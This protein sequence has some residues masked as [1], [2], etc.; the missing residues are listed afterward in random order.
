MGFVN[1]GKDSDEALVNSILDRS[2]TEYVN[3]TIMT[4]GPNA[5]EGSKSL[6]K[7]T[8]PNLIVA[9]SRA[10][11]GCTNLISID[12]PKLEVIGSS[13]FSQCNSLKKFFLKNLKSI[14]GSAFNSSRALTTLCIYTNSVCNLANTGALIGTPIS[15]GTGYIYVPEALLEEYKTAT[16]WVTY[17]DQFRAIED[18]PE[19]CEVN[20]ND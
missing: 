11:F 7:I 18:Y 5:F 8:M 6:E 10:F 4:L 15:A 9:N 3:N 17:A 13:A 19:I 20:S 14:G 12:M 1:F 16:N 2:I